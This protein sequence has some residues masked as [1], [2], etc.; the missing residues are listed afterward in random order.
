[1]IAKLIVHDVDRDRAIAR[2]LRALAEFRS[3]GRRR[4]SASTVRSSSTRASSQARRARRCQSEALAQRAQE[5]SRRLSSDNERNGWADGVFDGSPAGRRG[6]RRPQY[7]VGL[8]V[9]GVPW[10]VLA[11][12]RR[13][14]GGGGRRPETEGRSPDAG[15]GPQGGRRGGRQGRAGQELCVVEAIRWRTRSLPRASVSPDHAVRAGV[16]VASG[17]RVCVVAPPE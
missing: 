4:C 7:D 6:C 2:M 11:R 12:C 5:L 15:H 13:E 17:Q 9:T 16:A 1:M 10:S 8:Q 3:R 14:R